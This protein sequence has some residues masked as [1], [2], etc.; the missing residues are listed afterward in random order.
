MCKKHKKCCE[1][2]PLF[3]VFHFVFEVTLAYWKMRFNTIF[4]QD[5]QL[6]VMQ[7]L[8]TPGL[9]FSLL[10]YT[11]SHLSI[12]LSGMTGIFFYTT[13][14]FKRAG[15]SEDFSQYVTIGM[16][17]LV[18]LSSVATLPMMDRCDPSKTQSI[19]KSCY[20]SQ[21]ARTENLSSSV[22]PKNTYL[23]LC[24]TFTRKASQKANC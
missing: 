4:P 5:N 7:V 10:V 19:F 11:M 1:A 2:M 6:T 18:I 9:R 3:L 12:P 13:I 21:H 14:Y 17:L 15:L 22:V 23:L 8:K 24:W 16:C 20:N